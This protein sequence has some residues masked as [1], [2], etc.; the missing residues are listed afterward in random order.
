MF[1][2]TFACSMLSFL[3]FPLPAQQTG[4]PPLP[5]LQAGQVSGEIRVDG[6]LTEP[7][8]AAAPVAT[9]FTQTDPQEGQP[10]TQRTEVRILLGPDALYVGGWL[11][12]ANPRDQRPRLA[13]RDSPVDGDI[14]AVAFDS[15]NDHLSAYYFRVTS[16]GGVRDAVL[17]DGGH[18]RGGDLDLSW[19][20][21]WEANVTRDEKGW[22]VEMRIPLSQLPYNRVADGQW[23]IQIERFRWNTQERT[24]FAFTPKTATGGVARFGRLIGLGALPAPGRVEVTPYATARAQLQ[25]AALAS[26]LEGKQTGSA[27]AGVDLKLRATSSLTLNAT[28]N[29]DFGQ[30]EVDPAVVNLS[31]FETFFP[32]RRPF[33]V[34]GADLFE[35]GRLRAYNT[36]FAPT[37][38]HSR[39]IGRA[40]QGEVPGGAVAANLP[41]ASTIL[42]AAKLTGKSAGGWTVAALTA[43][44]AEEQATWL[45]GGGARHETPVEPRTGYGLARLRRE[46][47]GGDRQFGVFSS[48]VIRDLADPGLAAAVR[49][50]AFVTGIDFNQR[51]GRRTWA[52]DASLAVSAVSGT[53]EAIAATQRA[54]SRYLQ[55]PDREVTRYDPTLTSLRGFTGQIALTKTG[56]THWLGNLAYQTT[57]RG[58]ESSDLGFMVI[59]DRHQFSELIG[60]QETKPGRIFRNYVVALY[61]NHNFD[62]DWVRTYQVVSGRFEAGLKDFSGGAVVVSRAFSANEDQFTRGGPLVLEKPSV[63]TQLQYQSDPRRRWRLGLEVSGT[64]RSNGGNERQAGAS[65]ALQPNGTLTLAVSPRYTGQRVVA[66]PVGRSTDP[67]A[68]ATYGVRYLFGELKLRQMALETRIDWTYNPRLSFQMYLQALVSVGEYSHFKELRAPRTFEFNEFGVD[69]GSVTRANGE[70]HLTPAGAGAVPI[71]LADPDFNYRSLRANAVVRWEWNPGA[72]LFLVWQQGREGVVP[73]R[74]LDLAGALDQPSRNVFAIKATWWL[75][76]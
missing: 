37:V 47:A 9:A 55:R 43:V 54:S 44:T 3:A 24:L 53:A 10:G 68:T 7:D 57:S 62:Y 8:W 38:F 2:P 21:V 28:V 27:S 45:D 11:Y 22:Y 31:A 13:R 4:L 69:G 46:T 67:L 72:T 58:F 32:E 41:D 65:F 1:R 17:R 35:F 61:A 49:E 64:A 34:E 18:D 66:Q 15:R 16:G 26:A 42:G 74:G 71:A 12:E 63:S 76:R 39:R 52:L 25:S 19:D 30:V 48:A 29:P 40:P 14:F 50:R 70:V 20:A 51:M 75:A 33:F 6:R 36:G 59:A 23:G 60:Y 56:G 73:G 5:S